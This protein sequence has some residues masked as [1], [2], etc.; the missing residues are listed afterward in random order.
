MQQQ[1]KPTLSVFL[2]ISFRKMVSSRLRHLIT[3]Q[4]I[5]GINP[6]LYN[7]SKSVK[8]YISDLTTFTRVKIILLFVLI[9]SIVLNGVHAIC[10]APVKSGHTGFIIMFILILFTALVAVI[11]LLLYPIGFSE[12][13]N[14]FENSKLRIL[15]KIGN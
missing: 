1:R 6:I 13:L 11:P 5:F 9:L 4:Q 12:L 3:S 14:F 15:G 10:F 7:Y 2:C 8:F